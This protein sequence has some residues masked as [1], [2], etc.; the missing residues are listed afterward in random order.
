MMNLNELREVAPAVFSNSHNMSDRYAQV[1]TIDLLEPLLKRGFQITSANQDKPRRRDPMHVT[2]VVN[3]TIPGSEE[4]FKAEG[5]PEVIITNSHNGRTKLRIMAGIYRLVCSN[6]LVVGRGFIDPVAA[7]HYTN[8]VD[9]AV[10]AVQR[11]GDALEKMAAVV[12]QWKNVKLSAA[13]QT[14]LAR[15]AAA[16]RWGK[17]AGAYDLSEVLEARRDPDKGDDLWRVYNRVQENTVRGGL[18]GVSANGGN[19]RSRGMTAI[20]PTIAYN[21]DLWE[22]ASEFA[23]AQAA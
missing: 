13:K 18:A 3:L 23:I 11:T 10:D 21:N 15:R 17:S 12:D 4:S 16:L 5:R 22:I 19:V 1:R 8:S 14:E 20:L 7:S 6:G 2:H 9:G